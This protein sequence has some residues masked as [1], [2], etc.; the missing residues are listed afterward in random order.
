MDFMKKELLA[1]RPPAN[2]MHWAREQKG[3][4]R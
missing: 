1:E 2:V 4:R 3:K